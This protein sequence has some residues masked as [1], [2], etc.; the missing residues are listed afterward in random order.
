MGARLQ[1]QQIFDSIS[2][3]LS[4]LVRNWKAMNVLAMLEEPSVVVQQ[5]S[6]GLILFGVIAYIALQFVSAPYGRYHDKKLMSFECSVPG[7][8]GWLI[9]ESP[10]LIIP[11]AL[12]VSHGI[13]HLSNMSNTVLLSLYIIHYLYR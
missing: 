13:G 10:N 8:L 7:K 3:F 5:L 4:C 11:L 9:M 6:L 2:I 1:N 12:I